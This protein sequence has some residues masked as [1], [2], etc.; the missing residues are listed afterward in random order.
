M[1]K[2]VEAIDLWKIYRMGKGVEVA[3]LRGLNLSVDNGEFVAVTGPSGSGKSTFLHIV[4]CMDKPT[5][6]D[7]LF[8]GRSVAKMNDGEL[9]H[10]RCKQIGFVFQTFNL[11]PT[12]NALGNVEIP[13]RLAGVNK[14]TRKK[15]AKE[16]LIKVGLGERLTHLPREMSGGEQQ[17]VAI[18]RALA[19]NPKLVL[20]D[21]P[22]GNIDS[23][24]GQEIASLLHQLNEEGQTIIMVTHNLEIARQAKR[25]VRMR[26]GMIIEA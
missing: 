22:T 17:R 6:G 8:E 12:L 21:E 18:A 1:S 19:N 25:I 26:D 13:M 7:V 11:L 23:A 15:R 4:G 20:A 10:A 16:L 3:A 5:K 24:T 9:T 2:I 14:A